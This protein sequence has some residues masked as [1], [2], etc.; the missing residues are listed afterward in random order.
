VSLGTFLCY[1]LKADLY[2]GFVYTHNNN[3]NIPLQSRSGLCIESYNQ[4]PVLSKYKLQILYGALG[5][6]ISMQKA[7]HYFLNNG[8]QVARYIV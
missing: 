6:G 8:Y 3:K 4:E 2:K 7:K 1:I 5:L